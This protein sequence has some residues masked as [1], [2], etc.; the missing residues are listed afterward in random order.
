[1]AA[2]DKIIGYRKAKARLNQILDMFKNGDI[3]REMGAKLPHGV[4]LYGKPGMGKTLFATSFIEEAGVKTFSVRYV[5]Q[6]KVLQDIKKAFEDAAKEEKAIV[7]FDDI[8]KFSDTQS[9]NVDADAF[10]AIQSGIDSVKD[11]NV[12]V[13]ATANNIQK[14]P[15]S[16]IRN[17]RFD[18]KLRIGEPGRKDAAK[19]V[20]YYLRKR[21]VDSNANYDDITK[22][23]NYSSCADLA[24][25]VNEGAVI[26][27]YKRK[28]C[29]ETE[30]MVDAYLADA[31]Q[32]DWEEKDPGQRLSTALHE[33]G[34]VV[35]SEVIRKGSV[36][37]VSVRTVDGF[38]K[39]C[40][41]LRRRPQQILVYLAGKAACELYDKGRVASG[42]SQDLD[43]ATE[44]IR[45]GLVSNGTNGVSLLHPGVEAAALLSDDYKLR[46]ENALTSELERY[47][48]ACRDILI[49]NKDFLFAIRDELAKKGTLL[50]SDIERIR[51]AYSIVPSEYSEPDDMPDGGSGELGRFELPGQSQLG[52]VGTPDEDYYDE[53]EDC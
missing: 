23:I 10:V 22:M 19:I 2:F 29:V 41:P 17:G 47:L 33:A 49:K 25:I 26:A 16:L 43:V 1:M 5:S 15:E 34:H 24:K 36:G 37:L 50:N 39:R 14:L 7:F 8:D 45:N 44:L 48:F 53:D 4:L 11:K 27:A 31:Y 30:D 46:V 35:V 3:Y 13:V 12:L 32:D 28:K 52:Y 51:S 42:C 18:R 20:E 40:L 9:R 21:K 38:T 6:G